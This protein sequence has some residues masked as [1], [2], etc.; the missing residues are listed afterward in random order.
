MFDTRDIPDFF[1]SI[2]FDNGNI[3]EFN[4]ESMIMFY[5]SDEEKIMQLDPADLTTLYATY[6][7]MVRERLEEGM[8]G[9]ESIR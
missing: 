1:R 7:A 6:R 2:T 8:W 5:N 4:E 3:A 9:D